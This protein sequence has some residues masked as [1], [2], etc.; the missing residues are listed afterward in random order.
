MAGENGRGLKAFRY[1]PVLQLIDD[2]IQAIEDHA[3]YRSAREQLSNGKDINEIKLDHVGIAV[4][5]T[6]YIDE[7]IR[8]LAMSGMV[9]TYINSASDTSCAPPPMYSSIS[10][11]GNDS[12]FER[13]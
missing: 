2:G 13:D 12:I 7:H 9:A 5:I 11:D 3:Y 8:E 6:E 4:R 1:R 10:F